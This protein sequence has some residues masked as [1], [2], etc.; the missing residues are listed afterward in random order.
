[1]RRPAAGG[2]NS[3]IIFPQSEVLQ[4]PLFSHEERLRPL[5]RP[6]SFRRLLLSRLDC[7]VNTDSSEHAWVLSFLSP[8]LAEVLI[9]FHRDKISDPKLLLQGCQFPSCLQEAYGIGIAQHG[10]ADGLPGEPR[11]LAQPQ[12]QKGEAILGQGMPPFGEKE[13]IPCLWHR[14]LPG[15]R[16]T[17]LIQIGAHGALPVY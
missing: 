5:P 9:P 14:G 10:W 8:L 11:P 3:F 4:K 13:P 2:N 12:K 7:C 1:M 16:E 15:R 17:R 6:C